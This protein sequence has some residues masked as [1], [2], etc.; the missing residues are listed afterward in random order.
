M[1]I[2]VYSHGEAYS[3]GMFDTDD[4]D[5]DLNFHLTF[6]ASMEELTEFIDLT[7]NPST[8]THA[9]PKRCR[10]SYDEERVVMVSRVDFR[11]MCARSNLKIMHFLKNFKIFS[12]TPEHNASATITETLN[13]KPPICR[14]LRKDLV[15]MGTVGIRTI[16]IKYLM[17]HP[18]V[19]HLRQHRRRRK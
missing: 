16:L 17:L 14:F 15:N 4:D 3:E 5:D 19:I 18:I 10:F 11:M 2:G 12:V 6:P 1:N 9:Q 7:D 13:A 8:R